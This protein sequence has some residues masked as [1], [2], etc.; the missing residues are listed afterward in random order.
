M[1]RESEAPHYPTA[2]KFIA[3]SYALASLLS[4]ALRLY[5]IWANRK[6]E[7]EQGQ[8]DDSVEDLSVEALP[9]DPIAVISL[10]N[11]PNA[12]VTGFR[13]RL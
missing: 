9:E 11:A 10:P 12:D 1:F 5:L 4:L 8:S 6:W 2:F 3:G 13:Y 7:K